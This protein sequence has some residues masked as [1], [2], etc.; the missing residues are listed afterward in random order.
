MENAFQTAPLF[1]TDSSLIEKWQNQY[2]K[3]DLVDNKLS[4]YGLAYRQVVC[5]YVSSR[6]YAVLAISDFKSTRDEDNF[7]VSGLSADILEAYEVYN[8]TKIRNV[9]WSFKLPNHLANLIISISVLFY[10]SIFKK[11]I[12]FGWGA[13]PPRPPEFWLGGLC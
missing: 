3:F 13:L 4:K 6:L 12:G 9:G 11:K 5:N 1:G 8:S 7:I 10:F 2:F